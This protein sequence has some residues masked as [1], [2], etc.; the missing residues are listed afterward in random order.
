MR[1]LDM[2]DKEVNVEELD[3]DKGTLFPDQL[4]IKEHPAQDRIE[5]EQHF[6]V[7]TYFFSDGTSLDIEDENDPHVQVIDLDAGRF[8]YNNLPGEEEKNVHGI[9]LEYVIDKEGQ[10][11]REAWTEYEDIQRW[12]PYTEKELEMQEEERKRQEKQSELMENG[13]DYIKNLE[14]RAATTEQSVQETQTTLDDLV[15]VMA[16]IVNV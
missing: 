11:P 4:I 5:A 16:D 6:K 1:T 9:E 12:R 8:G 7:K 2:D 13:L 3:L 15:L 10:E 14:E